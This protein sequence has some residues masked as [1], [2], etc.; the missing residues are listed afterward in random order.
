MEAIIFNLIK[1]SNSLVDLC[2]LITLSSDIAGFGTAS[3]TSSRGGGA[4]PTER[5]GDG[6]GL[7][8][9]CFISWWGW[10]PGYTFWPKK[11]L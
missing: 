8:Q 5:L 4:V 6:E 3:A 10:R 11:A 7:N 2:F 1:L 9:G